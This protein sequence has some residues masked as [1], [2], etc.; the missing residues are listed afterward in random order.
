MTFWVLFK[1]RVDSIAPSARSSTDRASDFGSEGWGFESLRA[2]VSGS[3]EI[4]RSNLTSVSVLV[5]ALGFLAARFKSDI[6][7]PDAV[8]QVISVY[9]LFGIGLKGGV[10]LS[11][12]EFSSV[13]RPAIVTFILGCTVPLFAF[14]ALARIRKLSEIDRGAIAAHY[15]STSLVTFTAALVLLENLNKPYEGFATTLLAIMEIPGIIIGIFLATRHLNRKVSWSSSLKEILFGKTVILLIGG[16]VVGSISGSSGYNKVTP[17]F[18]DLL[19]GVLA[20]FLMHL[21]YLAGSQIKALKE[22]GFGL[23]IFA[24]IF[25]IF[26]GTLGVLGGALAGLSVGGATVLGVLCASASYIAA[27]AAVQVA[28]PEANPSLSITASLGLTFPFNLIFGIPALYFLASKI[29]G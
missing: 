25:P 9:L 16:L 27:P 3:L 24:I 10:S 12:A 20:L 29:V 7:I 21:G 22:V 2:H 4:A 28:L 1:K 8:Y 13:I 14:I 6:R 15:G 23:F 26:A 11:N 5:F 19:P 18:V 17:F